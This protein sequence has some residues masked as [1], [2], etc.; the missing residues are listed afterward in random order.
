MEKTGDDGIK[1]EG[2]TSSHPD[3]ATGE[4]T[5]VPTPPKLEK[6]FNVLSTIGMNFSMTS[7]PLAVG[8]YLSVVIGVGGSPVF[9]Y[10]YV[11]AV[12]L[13]LLVCASLAEIAAA[14]PHS[15]GKSMTRYVRNLYVWFIVYC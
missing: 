7:T 3:Y 2:I 6:R 4:T 9:V 15:S 11:V 12:F 14:L 1:F 10:G 13:N 8:T 5:V